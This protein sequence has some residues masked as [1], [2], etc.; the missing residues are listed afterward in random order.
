M[1]LARFYAA[2]LTTG[3][4][5]LDEAESN[6]ASKVLRS[7]VGEDVLLF[8]GLGNEG[9]GTIG[10]IDRRHVR[11]QVASTRFAPRDHHGR[12]SLAVAMPRGD[13]QRNVIEKIVELGVDHLLPIETER[14]VARVDLDSMARLARYTVEA[15]KQSG[16]NRF[17]HIY[18]S[19]P[20][21]DLI[22]DSAWD[23]CA[24]WVLHPSPRATK[25]D[26]V[27]FCNSKTQAGAS[28]S[29][30]FAIGP[31]GGFTDE[32]IRSA[33]NRGFA[34]LDLG[35]RILRVETAVAFAS[36]LGHLLTARHRDD[37]P[38]NR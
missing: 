15:C 32:E 25:V 35:E 21:K 11:V 8:D 31:E 22:L 6:H 9:F 19:I 3:D 16:R 4:V 28:P 26:E 20:W 10:S 7:K 29:C 34:I 2:R 18:P 14:S 13:R 36:V 23:G 17:P 37:S 1:G 38:A 30:L 24:R 5:E 12:I 27:V 33:E